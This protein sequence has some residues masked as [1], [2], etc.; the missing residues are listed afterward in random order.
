MKNKNLKFSEAINIALDYSLKKDKNLIC[1]G[2]GVNDP[3]RVF[4]TT[5]NLLEKYGESRVFDVPNSENTLMGIAVGAGLN[6]TKSIITHQRLDFFL[7][8][9]DQLVNSASKWKYM[10]GLKKSLPITIRLIIGRGWGQ[11]PTHSQNL[12]SWFY[13]IPGLKLVCPSNP[14]DAK[15]LL[16]NSIFDPNPVIFIEHRWLHNSIGPVKKKEKLSKLMLNKVF[17]KGK[18]ITII[19]NGYLTIEAIEASKI[20]KSNFGISCEIIDLNVIKPLNLDLILRSVKKTKRVLLLDT[21]MTTG[22]ISSDILAKIVQKNFKQLKA[23]PQILGL[24][25]VPVPSTFDGAKFYPRSQEIIQVILKILNIKKKL[26][27]NLFKV[28]YPIDTPGLWF[29]GPF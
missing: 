13:H 27:K 29:K 2:L 10:F 15:E 6:G 24:P 18:D 7:L 25:D 19:S 20:L 23:A 9:M 17:K 1:Y 16:I 28:A 26:N 5:Q 8:A 21:G 11:G 14:K 22:S 4:G 3:K 12:Q